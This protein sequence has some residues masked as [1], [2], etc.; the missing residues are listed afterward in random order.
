MTGTQKFLDL[1]YALEL[2]MFVIAI[3]NALGHKAPKSHA[4]CLSVCVCGGGGGLQKT[5]YSRQLDTAIILIV[6]DY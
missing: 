2:G 1:M 6:V 5:I 3:S 4:P